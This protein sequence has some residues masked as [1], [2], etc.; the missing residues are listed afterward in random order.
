[1][2]GIGLTSLDIWIDGT[3]SVKRLKMNMLGYDRVVD[4]CWRDSRKSLERF[5]LYAMPIPMWWHDNL[6]LLLHD[7][8]FTLNGWRTADNI[9]IEDELRNIN[10]SS[11]IRSSLLFSTLH[12]DH[13]YILEGGSFRVNHKAVINGKVS[14]NILERHKWTVWM[15]CF[16]TPW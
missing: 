10:S 2:L 12:R 14:C 13:A 9:V 16:Y 5:Y 11:M 15:V 1:M 3:L 8:A 7:L 6:K 4:Y